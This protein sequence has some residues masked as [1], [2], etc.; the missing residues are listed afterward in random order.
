ME[1]LKLEQAVELLRKDKERK[2]NQ[3]IDL[4]VNLR[5]FDLK[6]TQINTFV[7]IPHKIKD[8]KVCGFIESKSSIINTIQKSQFPIYKDKKK[9]KKLVKEYDFF[10]ASAPNMP[11]VATTFGRVLGPAGKMPSPKLGILVDDSEKNVKELVE[12]INKT[13]RVQTKEPSIKVSIGKLSMKDS[14]LI[15][16]ATQVYNSIL[17]ELPNNKDNI[18]SVMIKSTMSKSLRVEM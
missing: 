18:K 8:K 13:I 9:V 5:K 15:E 17:N 16:N 4:I 10:I 2:F 3:S 1:M 7:S 14:E 6:K 12:R 11:L